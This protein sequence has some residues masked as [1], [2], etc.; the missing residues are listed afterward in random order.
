[1]LPTKLPYRR[2]WEYKA[3]G[4]VDMASYAINNLLSINFRN[5]LFASQFGGGDGGAQI[6]AAIDYLGSGGGMVIVDSRNADGS[7]DIYWTAATVTI[8]DHVTLY[9]TDAVT[10][11]L[12]ASSDVPIFENSELVGG[13]SDIHILGPGTVHGNAANQS[14]GNLVYFENVANF[15]IEQIKVQNAYKINAYIKDCM[16]SR[17]VNV[18]SLNGGEGLSAGASSGD[19]FY[20]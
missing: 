4:N 20:L 14:D 15:S 19:A 17:L 12:T 18:I 11:K 6:Q 2:W 9:I 7:A 13:N 5:I 8:P 16:D 1:M 10:V 3:E